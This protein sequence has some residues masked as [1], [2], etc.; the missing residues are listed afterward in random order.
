VQLDLEHRGELV[1]EKTARPIR[2]HRP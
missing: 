1:R 2:W